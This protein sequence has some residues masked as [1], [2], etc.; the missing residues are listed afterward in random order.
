MSQSKDLSLDLARIRARLSA[1][2]GPHYWRCLEELA[3]TEEFQELLHREFPHQA[4]EGILAI[5]RRQFLT[6]LGASL[7][8]AGLSGCAV[9]PP[10]EKILPYIRQPEELVPGKPLY[11]ATAMT[12]GGFATGLLVESHEGR[13]TKIEGNPQHPASLGATDVFAQASILTLYDPD[14]SQA[15]TSLGRIRTWDQALATLQTT[16]AGQR[17]TGGAGLR[18]LTET[19]T[20]PTLAGQI[21]ALRRQ[22]PAMKW[23]KYLP[24]GIEMSRAGARLAFGQDVHTYYRLDHADVI[25]SLD[26]DFFT[27][28]P[29]HLR[30]VREFIGRRRPWA[31][32]GPDAAAM[33]RL[34]VVEGSPTITG[35][36]ADHRWRLRSGDVE[37]FARTLATEVARRLSPE[38]VP[39]ANRAALALLARI[40]PEAALPIEA[41]PAGSIQ[42]LAHD[43]I[44][45]QN[46]AS[47]FGRSVVIAGEGQPPVV[48]ALAH[49]LNHALGNVGKTV[50]Y[51]DPV[52]VEPVNQAESLAELVKDMEAS[53][54][55]VLVIL[56]G[57]PVFTA[58]A[59]LEFDKHLSRVPFRL[60]LSLYADET[61]E[62]CHWHIPATY[63]LESWSDARAYDGTASIIQPLIAP[64]YSGTSVHELVLA[65]TGEPERTS[66]ELVREH[67][68]RHWQEQGGSGIFDDFWQTALHEGVVPGTAF[69]PRTPSLRGD[70]VDKPAAKDT[71]STDRS[72]FEIIFRPD[73]TI[74]D[75]QFANNGWLQELPKPLTKLTWD[76][77][78]CVSPRTAEQ[79][80]L[81]LT[82]QRTGGEHGGITA[83][84]V[85]LHYRGRTVRAPV[86]IVPG[87][88]DGAVTVHL[89]Y[90][91]T[92]AG[93]VGTGVGYNAYTLRTKDAPWFDTGLEV[94]KTGERVTL[95]CTQAHF[96]MEGRH[97]V[98]SGTFA[99]YRQ[100]RHFATQ[101]EERHNGRQ[102][103]TL[104]DPREHPYEGYKWGMAIDLTACI[105]C[106]A[107]VVA[108]Q[109]ENN[110]PVVGQEEVRRG[111]EMH[112]LRID[113][114]YEGGLD[115]PRTHFQP[116][117]CMH[118]ENAPCEL[119]CPV[120]ATVHSAEGLNDM[121]YNRCV[122]TR[123]CSNNCPYKVR[124]FNFLQYS[125]YAT[126]SLK[127]LHNP[128]VT[129]RTRGVMEKCTY[130]VQRI[131]HARIEAEKQ[132]RRVRDG[133]ILTACQAACPA[134]AI[135]F[136]D[137]NDSASQ[138]ARWKSQPLD[139][140]LLTDLNT[141][142]R[143]TYLAELQNPN[144][145]IEAS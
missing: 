15:V 21:A 95:A 29:G 96:L 61:S 123:Y 31:G 120:E 49:T 27:R 24:T 38:T 121:V 92:R 66:Y 18:L 91:R 84:V 10:A 28:G 129:V 52:Q 117:P 78:A 13:P 101:L 103:L 7:T 133:E 130:C 126:E 143:T 104:Y 135:A 48:H 83:D 51:T 63:Y 98:R 114:Y 62:L 75:G 67:W 43:L 80:G 137:L 89:G 118:C 12:H 45:D 70:W 55:E 33:N 26:A 124:R 79:L 116:V 58:P 110:I 85:E 100:N 23:A 140:G 36:K 1:A 132:D 125:D 54:V 50:V 72:H 145:D 6:V 82:P 108:C 93:R 41:I 40:N 30:Y 65:L 34:Y 134:E 94:R 9:Q 8:M 14:R 127:L 141:R 142:P 107:C 105:G 46:K 86:W 2:H 122:G 60:H 57:N 128:D 25:V 68:R 64:L 69:P 39:E 77:V 47:R 53:R 88:A 131:N 99:Q 19:V 81:T 138:V 22:F 113:R 97:L 42:A 90:G 71:D 3:A 109:A 44:E 37:A 102:S 17:R 111:R 115:N 11:F 144:P 74:D 56:G 73:P 4:G 87:H 106:N 59:D 5:S 112:W 76:N 136:G 35:A 32:A 119:V 16:L 139:Y 20:S